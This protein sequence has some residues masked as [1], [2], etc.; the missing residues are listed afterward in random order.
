MK[1]A[2]RILLTVYLPLTMLIL[3]FQALY[4]DTPPALYLMFAVRVT[5]VLTVAGMQ[6]AHK[7]QWILALA[8]LCTLFSDYYFELTR[9]FAQPVANSTLYGMLGFIAAYLCLIAAFNR[10]FRIG[11][12]ELLTAI[13]FVGIFT[14]VFLN[15]KQYAK[16][17]MYPAAIVIGIVLC[18]AAVTMVATLYR[19]YFT[20][21]MAWLIALAGCLLF[22]S[23]MFVAYSIFHPD[24]Q[25]FI[26][27][28]E[29]IVW[30]TYVPAWT[31]FMIV[32]SEDTLY[33]SEEWG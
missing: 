22:I 8:F 30:G 28:K 21:K 15:L 17:V 23:D 13:P 25:K 6:K 2:Q 11:K 20:I 14:Y 27:L 5:M 10:N 18:A 7:E 3:W 33:A 19:G 12:A 9:T 29:N 4:R 1:N 16:G 26:L 24:F 31:F 32:A